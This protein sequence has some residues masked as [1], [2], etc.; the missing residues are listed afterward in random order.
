MSCAKYNL[1]KNHRGMKYKVGERKVKFSDGKEDAQCQQRS[2]LSVMVRIMN[3][4]GVGPQHQ[5][6]PS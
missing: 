1:S 4:A 6:L 2:I 3:G 5:F